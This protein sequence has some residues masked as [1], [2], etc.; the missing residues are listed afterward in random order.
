MGSS[1]LCAD[2]ADTAGKSGNQYPPQGAT[3]TEE[4]KVNGQIPL[5][6]WW[7]TLKGTRLENPSAIQQLRQRAIP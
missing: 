7:P 5:A 2:G 4:E 3:E 6:V 1:Q